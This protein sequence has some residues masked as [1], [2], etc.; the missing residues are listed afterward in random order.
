MGLL[1]R[2]ASDASHIVVTSSLLPPHRLALSISR[3][4]GTPAQQHLQHYKF[5][6]SSSSKS[7]QPRQIVERGIICC[8]K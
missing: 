1:N 2:K 5:K 8:C 6:F 4:D 3:D 7:E